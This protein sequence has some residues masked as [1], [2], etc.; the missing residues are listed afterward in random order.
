MTSRSRE[1]IRALKM[2]IAAL[3]DRMQVL[4][5]DANLFD[6]GLGSISGE[7]ASRKR[8]E[9]LAAVDTLQE[10]IKEQERIEAGVKKL[11]Q[12]TRRSGRKADGGAGVDQVADYSRGIEGGA[13]DYGGVR[14]FDDCSR[15]DVSAVLL[16]GGAGGVDQVS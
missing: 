11:L 14:S 15:V 7:R 8:K 16:D 5:F 1:R 4:A 10:L 12:A 6:S 13:V 2:G 3:H 9:M